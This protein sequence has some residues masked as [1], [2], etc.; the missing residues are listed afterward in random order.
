MTV[1]VGVVV[2]P[3]SLDDA[4]ACRAVTRAG[5]TYDARATGESGAFAGSLTPPSATHASK[6][7]RKR[8]VNRCS[9]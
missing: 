8:A 1:R 5:G 9:T 6:A 3:G 7:V 4:D 2:F